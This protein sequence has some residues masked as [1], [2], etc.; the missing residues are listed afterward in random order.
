M[1][2]KSY[3]LVDAFYLSVTGFFIAVLAYT[4][5]THFESSSLV[6]RVLASGGYLSIALIM[7]YLYRLMRPSATRRKVAMLG[8]LLMIISPIV[9][10]IVYQEVVIVVF[11]S[12]FYL[13][14]VAFGIGLPLR[15]FK[16]KKN[17]PTGVTAFPTEN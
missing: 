11:P 13:P 4:Q 5:A 9:Y 12:L 10:S 7:T 6:L 1:N 15:H 14:G 8:V 2:P 3:T 17:W 16:T